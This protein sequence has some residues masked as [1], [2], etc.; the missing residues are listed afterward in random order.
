MENNKKKTTVTPITLTPEEKEKA[1]RVST[2]LFGSSNYSGLYAY[3][4]NKFDEN[5]L[6]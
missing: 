4:I 1:R 2:K 5:T 6:L 3:F